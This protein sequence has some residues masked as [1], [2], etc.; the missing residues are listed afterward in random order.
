MQLPPNVRPSKT[1]QGYVI[2]T[3]EGPQPWHPDGQAFDLRDYSLPPGHVPIEFE[4]PQQPYDFIKDTVEQLRRACDEL[5]GPG[6][7]DKVRVSFLDRDR[8]REDAELQAHRAQ[9][10]AILDAIRVS[11]SELVARARQQPSP[12]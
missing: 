4:T 7:F 9:T 3:P 10:L 8:E 5:F 11:L 1:G 12:V 2:D 6:G